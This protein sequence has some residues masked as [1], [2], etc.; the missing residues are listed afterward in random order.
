MFVCLLLACLPLQQTF[1]PE[2][3]Q[4][5]KITLSVF[6]LARGLNGVISVAQG[7]EMSIEPMGVGLTLTPGEILDP[8]NDLVEQFSSVLLLA[9]ASLGVQNIVLVLGDHL[10]I[11]GALIAM[12]LLVIILLLLPAGRQQAIKWLPRL[13]IMLTLVRL[14]VPTLALVSHQTQVWLK[15][16]RQQAVSML[17]STRSTVDELNQQYDDGSQ[18]WFSDLRDKLDIKARL[19]QIQAR[20]EQAVEAAV[21]LLA[22][23]VLI[24][25]LMPLLFVYMALK[26][27]MRLRL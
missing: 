20:A 23:F 3:T 25:V 10:A 26:L 24:M 19:E 22:E 12:A 8:L 27:P 9:S 17:E 7:T 4:M 14:L 18:G 13:V 6:A 5:L 2:L 15:S 16:E 1:A 11:R 21:Y